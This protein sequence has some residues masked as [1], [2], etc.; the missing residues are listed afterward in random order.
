VVTPV[1]IGDDAPL[2]YYCTA[3]NGSTAPSR[4]EAPRTCALHCKNDRD[5]AGEPCKRHFTATPFTII[6]Q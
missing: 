3:P 5:S 1:S 4:G 2:L 6:C